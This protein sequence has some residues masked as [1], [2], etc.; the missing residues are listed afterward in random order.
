VLPCLLDTLSGVSVSSLAPAPRA[1]STAAPSLA[2]WAAFAASF[3]A[4]AVAELGDRTQLALLAA[5]SEIPRPWALF[6][7]ASLAF[8]ASNVL[9]VTVG[10]VLADVLPPGV[11]DLLA[12]ALF[13]AF[14]LAFAVRALRRG[15]APL[16]DEAEELPGEARGRAPV[17]LALTT[18][19]SIF[20]AET[21]DKTQIATATLA[22]SVSPIPVFLGATAALLANAGVAIYL[23][24]R[25]AS[26]P[27]SLRRWLTPV[28]AA[29][30]LGFAA[31]ALSRGLA[32]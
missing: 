17:V 14:G 5:A 8:A 3:G 28:A 11:M 21:G 26:L 29:L 27:R 19:A 7:G 2:G 13:A 15:G 23:G 32:A 4:V 25:L 31:L 9:A 24:R 12:A 18:T 10:A 6:A 22:A 20:L 1:A 16:D 30:F